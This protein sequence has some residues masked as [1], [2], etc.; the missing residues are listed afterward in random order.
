MKELNI[1]ILKSKKAILFDFVFENIT[2]LYGNNG[3]G[4]STI[5]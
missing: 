1:E 3:A 2:V 5:I 4:K